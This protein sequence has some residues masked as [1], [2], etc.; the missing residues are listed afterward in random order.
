MRGRGCHKAKD[1]PVRDRLKPEG[2]LEEGVG[3][4]RE[5]WWTQ[6]TGWYGETGWQKPLKEERHG[7]RQRAGEDWEVQGVSGSFTSKAGQ[8]GSV[9]SHV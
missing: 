1:P 7:Q 2:F 4:V 3:M 9:G 8:E 6:Q 5:D